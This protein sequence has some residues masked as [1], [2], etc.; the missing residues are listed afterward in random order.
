MQKAVRHQPISFDQATRLIQNGG[1]GACN[2]M[3]EWR[4]KKASNKKQGFSFCYSQQ[5]M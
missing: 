3:N 1:T 2:I 5:Q 4:Q